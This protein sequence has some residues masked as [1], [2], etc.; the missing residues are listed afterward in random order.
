MKLCECG[1]GREVKTLSARFSLGHSNKSS[2]VKE[3]KRL[4]MLVKYG[5]DNPSKCKEIQ[6][7]KIETSRERYGV[8]NPNQSDLVKEK[9]KET[10]REHFGVD[11]PNQSEEIKKKKIST[12]LKNRGT[13]Y[14]MQSLEVQ[15]KSIDTCRKNN[16][17]DFPYQNEEIRK[18]GQETCQKN[19]GV[20]NPSQSD[21]IKKKKVDTSLLHWGY[22][23]WSKSPDGLI[24]HREHAIKRIEKY[25]L[26]GLPLM[27]NSG[28]YEN[29]LLNIIEKLISYPL[30]KNK[31]FLGCYPDGLIKELNLVIE[32]D[33][34]HHNWQYQKM[35]D[36]T[37]NFIYRSYKVNYIRIKIKDWLDNRN[38]VIQNI[39]CVIKG[40]EDIK[41]LQDPF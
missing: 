28:V 40:L 27:P 13:Y 4:A 21:D 2:E 32:F 9:K 33:E 34:M 35:I 37:K 29:E 24:Y 3:K 19:L 5:V 11:N 12:N 18:R 8:D 26:L 30:I 41:R 22:S 25:K 1:C 31:K 38:E 15:T 17:V 7:K 39:L 20:I 14:P 36:I 16:G 23:N 10:S 6:D